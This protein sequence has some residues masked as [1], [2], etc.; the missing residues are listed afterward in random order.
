[1]KAMIF[2]AGLGTRLRPITNDIPKALAPVHGVPMLEIVI[3]RLIN[4]GFK[5]IVVN[6]HHFADKMMDFLESKDMFN[7]NLHISDESG[8]LLDTGG[9]LK[10]AA[11]FFDDGKPFLVHNV[12]TLTNIDLLDY[13]NYHK[14]NSALATLLVRHRPGSRFF[15][16][17]EEKRLC[18]WENVETNEKIV[19]VQS[20][21]NLEQIA[22]S[23]LHIIDPKIF[24]LITEEG[25]FSIIDTYLRLA[26][27]NKIMGYLDD[28][29]YWLDIGTPEKLQRAENE[30]DIEQFIQRN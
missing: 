1:M 4:Y 19:P 5:D 29:S 11:W 27:P 6:V 26:E 3:R 20:S 16:F 8:E 7:I 21:T 2:A 30:L 9:G 17:D 10:K 23:C 24:E 13:Y 14:K 22:F 18:G 25:C 12:D 28:K 15:L